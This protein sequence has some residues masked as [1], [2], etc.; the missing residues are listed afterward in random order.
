MEPVRVTPEAEVTQLVRVMPAAPVA[1]ASPVEDM[2]QAAVPE[3]TR[4]IVR[5]AM[6][7]GPETPPAIVAGT[8]AGIAEETSAVTVEEMLVVIAAETPAAIAAG[9]SAAIAEARAELLAAR[10]L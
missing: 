3:G 8:R 4:G 7:A 2:L 6:P 9:T 5:E 1:K 10:Y